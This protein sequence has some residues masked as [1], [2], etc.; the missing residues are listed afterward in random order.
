[1]LAR[2]LAIYAGLL[3]FAVMLEK[4]SIRQRFWLPKINTIICASSVG[5]EGGRAAE[6]TV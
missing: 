2:N 1:M 6:E 4:C 3:S 5:G